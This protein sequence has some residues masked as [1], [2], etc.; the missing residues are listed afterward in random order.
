MEKLIPTLREN[1][2]YIKIKTF[3]DGIDRSVLNKALFSFLGE[4][5]YARAGIQFITENIIKVE[6]HYVD[7]VK[8]A[9]ML[10][11]EFNSQ[12]VIVSSEKTSGS[13][14]KLKVYKG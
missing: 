14:K 9:L 12:P 10:V 3:P 13:L 6:R 8:T 4:L 11:K 1:K 5:E 7:K 2:R